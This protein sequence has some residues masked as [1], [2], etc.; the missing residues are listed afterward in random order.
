MAAQAVTALGL[1]E[2]NAVGLGDLHRTLHV[3]TAWFRKLLRS[4]SEEGF[5]A[6]SLTRLI[7]F[8]ILVVRQACSGLRCKSAMADH[9]A[10]WRQG[11]IPR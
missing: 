8:L 11:S 5:E 9:W 3:W 4:F 1:H 10:R 2:M 6:A 7:N